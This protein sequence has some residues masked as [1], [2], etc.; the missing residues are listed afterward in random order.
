MAHRLYVLGVYDE[1]TSPIS[2]DGYPSKPEAQRAIRWQGQG[3]F[4]SAYHI[5]TPDPAE[6][7]TFVAE[8]GERF[9][10]TRGGWTE[11]AFARLVTSIWGA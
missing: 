8:S 9:K 5:C 10:P 7:G 3:G 1:N 6:R 2:L 11:D 4:G